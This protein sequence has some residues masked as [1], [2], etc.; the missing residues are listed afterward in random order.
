MA[1]GHKLISYYGGEIPHAG[2]QRELSA[3]LIS[4]H[5]P[6]RHTDKYLG[7]LLFLF[8]FPYGVLFQFHLRR[9]A[10]IIVCYELLLNCINILYLA[11]C[12]TTPYS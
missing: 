7:F 2:V 6:L 9:Y 3:V 12:F 8:F 4:Q 5:S 10:M 11:L 1:R